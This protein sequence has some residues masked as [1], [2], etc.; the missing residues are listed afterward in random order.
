MDDPKAQRLVSALRDADA[1]I[2]AS[3]A[4]H[5]GLSGLLQTAL[6]YVEELRADERPYLHMRAVGCIV[7]VNG[8]QGIGTSPTS[9][10]SITHARRAADAARRG[11]NTSI[12]SIDEAGAVLGS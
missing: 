6:D 2:L 11:I 12:V 3:P 5:G 1:V 7:C 8:P 4:Y 10:R 9:M